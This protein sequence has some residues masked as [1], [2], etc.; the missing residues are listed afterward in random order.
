MDEGA[1]DGIR[2]ISVDRPGF[3]LSDMCPGR[4]IIDW[5]FD[6]AV[7]ADHLGVERFHVL[8]VSGGG[9]YALACAVAL[10]D[11]V[12]GAAIVCGGAPSD[13]VDM[14]SGM[15]DMNSLVFGAARD[16]PSHL[17]E[18]LEAMQVALEASGGGVPVMLDD[19]CVA[20]QAALADPAFATMLGA[21]MREAFRQGAAG[22]VDDMVLFVSPWGFDPAEVTVDVVVA[23]GDLDVNVPVSC[24][25]WLAVT[26]PS[27]RFL[28]FADDGHFSLAARSHEIVAGMLDTVD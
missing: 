6:I 23:H 2:L 4:R 17:R 21:G 1:L 13:R 11:R 15:S 26:I 12:A 20:D 3:G 16:D 5:P 25:E 19:L 28:R 22:P 14:F 27:A 24:G 7:L 18:L 10:P 9:P 8:G